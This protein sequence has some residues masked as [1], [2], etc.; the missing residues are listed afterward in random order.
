[1][2][3]IFTS[4]IQAIIVKEYNLEDRHG[5]SNLVEGLDGKGKAQFIKFY[6]SEAKKLTT[7]SL[8][9]KIKKSIQKNYVAADYDNNELFLHKFKILELYIVGNSDEQDYMFDEI[10]NIVNIDVTGYITRKEIKN[11]GR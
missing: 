5:I 6:M 4:K 10:Q 1:M 11:I 7:K 9:E 8:L 2:N 3:E